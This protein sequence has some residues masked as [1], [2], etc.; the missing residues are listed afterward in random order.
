MSL[1][2]N[3]NII[4]NLIIL[5]YWIVQS[6]DGV[7]IFGLRVLPF[8]DLSG[9]LDHSLVIKDANDDSRIINT[10]NRNRTLDSYYRG[11]FTLDAMSKNI[12]AMFLVSDCMFQL[13]P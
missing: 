1:S 10:T 7:V 3:Y 2:C 6:N 11:Y 5:F 4:S 8:Y 13:V 12:S 9:V